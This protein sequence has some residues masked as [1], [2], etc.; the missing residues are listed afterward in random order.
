MPWSKR[1]EESYEMERGDFKLVVHKHFD[2]P[3]K[4]CLSVFF[5]EGALRP[6][7]PYKVA[8]AKVEA[9]ELFERLLSEAKP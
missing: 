5:R 8:D 6:L 4:W 2:Y 7:S 1:S 3:G 9:L